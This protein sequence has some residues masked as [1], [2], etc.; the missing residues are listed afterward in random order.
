M[1]QYG[2]ASLLMLGDEHA[3]VSH[4]QR[5]MQTTH[6]NRV[7]V[8]ARDVKGHQGMRAGRVNGVLMVCV[9]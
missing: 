6:Q 8:T 3:L 5:G 4:A 9:G 1:V 2:I 7:S